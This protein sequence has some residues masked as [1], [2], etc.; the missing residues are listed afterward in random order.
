MID[1]AGKVWTSA[2]NSRVDVGPK[3]DKSHTVRFYD[4]TLRDGEQ[5]VGVVFSPQQKL[6]IAKKL[7]ELGVGRIEAGFPKVS[8]EDG[9][10]IALILKAGLKHSEVW[11]FARATRGDVEELAR[12]GL[13]ASVIEVPTSEV[14]LKAYGISRDEAVRRASEAISFATQQGIRVA[15]FGV[16]GS[17]ADLDF[18]KRIYSAAIEA[19]AKE[20]VLVDTIGVCTPEAAEFLV[21]WAKDWA[22]KD[23]PI[24]WHGHNDFGLGTA[25]AIAAVRGGATWIQ[26]TINGMG[27]RAGNADI[28][29]VALALRCLYDVPVEMNL[30]RI[31]EVSEAVR[32][33]GKYELEGWKPLIGDNLFLRESG[34][35]AS[36]FHIPEAIEP[37]AAALVGATRGI[38]LG[39]KSGLDSIRLKAEQLG[40]TVPE[41]QRGAVLE[42]VKRKA[43]AHGGLVSDDEFRGIVAGNIGPDATKRN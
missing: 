14:K 24:H 18:L 36:Q 31:R 6:E 23:I 10:A 12:L 25:I 7:D 20:I 28:A 19:G 43:I 8:A 17:R 4:T 13:Q 11:G 32:R 37:Y 22:G 35:V 34:A 40:L 3:F 9:E 26:G 1:L 30:E 16:D 41:P 5:T 29:E 2:L 38:V 15:F 42:A 27:E 39:K 33:A 21:R